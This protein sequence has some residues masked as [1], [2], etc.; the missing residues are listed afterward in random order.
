[1]RRLAYLLTGI[2][3]LLAP[4]IACGGLGSNA[5]ATANAL[6]V[7]LDQTATAVATLQVDAAA[8]VQTAEAAATERSAAAEATQAAQAIQAGD[9]AAATAAAAAPIMALLPAYG[10]DPSEGELGWIHP[11][12][13]LEAQGRG[14]IDYANRF[15]GTLVS[16]FVVSADITWNNESPASGCGFALRSD[17]NEDALNQNLVFMTRL[18]TV[19]F[20]TQIGGGYFDTNSRGLLDVDPLYRGQNGTTNNLTVVARGDVF[21]VFTNGLK[22]ADFTSDAYDRGFV[23]MVAVSEGG[24]TA[25]DFNNAWLWILD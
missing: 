25:C 13:A 18:A 16:D 4:L 1:M 20:L 9:A 14:E 12:L 7:V 23:A 6:V 22:I 2:I 5:E 8:A 15:L 11:P 24:R 17:G 21:S 3:G 10:V 19:S